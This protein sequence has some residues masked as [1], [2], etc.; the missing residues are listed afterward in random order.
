[1]A[2]LISSNRQHHLPKCCIF[3]K[4]V[5]LYDIPRCRNF[6]PMMKDSIGIVDLF[7]HHCVRLYCFLFKVTH[8]P[9]ANFRVQNVSHEKWVHENSLKSDNH[10][11]FQQTW[12][13]QIQEND[14]MEPLIVSLLNQVMNPPIVSFHCPETSQMATHASHHTGNTGNSF[15]EK[16]SGDPFFFCHV[17]RVVPREI[18]VWFSDEF[19]GRVSDFVFECFRNNMFVFDLLC[20]RDWISI[21]G[22]PVTKSMIDTTVFGENFVELF[23]ALKDDFFHFSRYNY[24]VIN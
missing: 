7:E 21:M 16:A 11:S 12:F 6:V 4:I 18:V 8:K 17:F 1:M 14:Q 9:M 3:R 15:E 23:E 10:R 19:D 2:C 5:I 20:F 24:E 22:H 13:P